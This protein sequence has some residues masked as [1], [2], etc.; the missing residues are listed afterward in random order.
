[1]SYFPKFLNNAIVQ[2]LRNIVECGIEVKP[3]TGRSY[4]RPYGSLDYAVIWYNEADKESEDWMDKYRD[5]TLVLTVFAR[6]KDSLEI[7]IDDIEDNAIP[8]YGVNGC[9]LYR[10]ICAHIETKYNQSVAEYNL[11]RKVPSL[12]TIV[13]PHVH[14]VDEFKDI[15]TRISNAI[16][17]I[18][19]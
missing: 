6:M 15:I 18:Q 13:E 9:D 5:G 4:W 17:R 14:H 12:A 11:R 8:R 7:V 16:F 1:M 3:R 19:V 2:S 10:S